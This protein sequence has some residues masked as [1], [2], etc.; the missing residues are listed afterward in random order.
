MDPERLRPVF[1]EPGPFVTLH[2]DVSRNDE[3]GNDQIE[4]RWTT[5]RHELE[6]ASVPDD[7]VE[8]IGSVLR[9]NTHLPGEVRRTVVA[10]RDRI[11]LDEVQSGHNPHPEVV[12]SAP[13]PDLAGWI[14][15]EDQ[16]CPFVLAVVDRTGGDVRTYRATSQP[17]VAEKS[18]AGETF[19]IT[20]VAEGDWA[21]YR[22]LS[23]WMFHT[24]ADALPDLPQGVPAV[25]LVPARG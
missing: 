12:D 8:R 20:K 3:H 24:P 10:A 22:V 21:A 7:L 23:L 14:D 18:V 2:V 17:P 13:L 9:E 5:V 4:S 11:V 6:H 25:A 19:Y 15:V 1:E 16:A